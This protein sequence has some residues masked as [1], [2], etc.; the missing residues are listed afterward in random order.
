MTACPQERVELLQRARNDEIHASQRKVH[1]ECTKALQHHRSHPR[2]RQSAE[3]KCSQDKIAASYKNERQVSISC[4][5]LASSLVGSANKYIVAGCLALPDVRVPC[6]M[7]LSLQRRSALLSAA[8]TL[9]M[10]T[11]RSAQSAP[12]PSRVAPFCGV[13]GMAIAAH[14][15]STQACRCI[16]DCKPLGVLTLCCTTL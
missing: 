12:T 4:R 6:R 14:R 8:A 15:I 10:V 3:V 5:H 16:T 11:A 2:H 7:S 13:T 1:L 9:P